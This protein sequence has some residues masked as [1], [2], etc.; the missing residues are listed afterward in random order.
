MFALPTALGFVLAVSKNTAAHF[1]LLR[2]AVCSGPLADEF[3][4][5]HAPLVLSLLFRLETMAEI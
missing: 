1:L 4:K 5:S 3:E 2:A